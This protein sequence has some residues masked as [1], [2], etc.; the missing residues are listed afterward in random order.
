MF[1]YVSGDSLI[2]HVHTATLLHLTNNYE[3]GAIPQNASDKDRQH[4][5]GVLQIVHKECSVEVAAKNVD[6]LHP[7]TICT[8]FT[9]NKFIVDLVQD[10]HRV[11]LQKVRDK[12]NSVINRENTWLILGVG[13][14][15][16]LEID[17]LKREY[18]D[19][20]FEILSHSSNGWP[21]ILWVELHAFSGY[22]R[23]VEGPTMKKIENFN[24]LVEEYLEKRGAKVLKTFEITKNVKSYDGRHHGL[25]MNLLK[26]DL[27]MN[28]LEQFYRKN[29]KKS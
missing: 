20:V 1:F 2:R 26:V 15:Y 8:G 7:D 24:K 19:K 5:S 4:C 14:H 21:K 28:Y 10:Y 17:S 12:I 9:P 29:S 13:L 11:L 3:T 27:I 23:Q 16:Q 22:I 25:G 6:E 18:L